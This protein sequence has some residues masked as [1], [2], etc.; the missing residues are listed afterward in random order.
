[1]KRVL[2]TGIDGFIGHHIAEGILKQT[3][4]KVIGLSKIDTA[5]TLHRLQDIEFWSQKYAG[6][7]EFVFHDLRA[8]INPY[9]ANRIGPVNYILHLA[10]STHVDRSIECPMEFVQD[11][12]LR[13]RALLIKNGIGTSLVI[14]MRHPRLEEKS[15][16]TVTTTRTDFPS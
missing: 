5:S 9:V 1:M 2:L 14:P 10:A 15:S 3:D 6:R 12:V 4:W 16:R 11:N 13:Q 8:P 7:V